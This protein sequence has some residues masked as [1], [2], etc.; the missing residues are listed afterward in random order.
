MDV[1]L[2]LILK[3]KLKLTPLALNQFDEMATR[4]GEIP[5]KT[6]EL[7]ELQ[8]YL[9]TSMTDTMPILTEKIE[10]SPLKNE[11]SLNGKRYCSRLCG[12]GPADLIVVTLRSAFLFDAVSVP[13]VESLDKKSL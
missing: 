1:N 5:E 2:I 3:V 8:R 4:L 6:R 9:K 12:F 10:V 11:N 7:V 13:K